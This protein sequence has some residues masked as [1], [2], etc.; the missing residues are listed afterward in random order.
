GRRRGSLSDN[1]RLDRDRIVPEAGQRNSGR[2]GWK[3]RGGHSAWPH[4]GTLAFHRRGRPE[5]RAGG[6][7]LRTACRT[8]RRYLPF[9]QQA[10][11]GGG[12]RMMAGSLNIVFLGLSLSSSWGNGHATTFRA[13]M[14][15]LHK[16]GHRL[17]FLE[18][19]VSWY[20][21][22]RDLAEPDFCD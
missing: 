3:G 6:A 20:A 19:D 15:G 21:N 4:C 8:C 14:R 22:N 16:L 18:R 5:T 13:L 9:F 12:G 1:R 10:T 11:R 7:Y 17:I 2:T